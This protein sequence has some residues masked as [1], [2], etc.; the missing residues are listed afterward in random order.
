MYKIYIEIT[1]KDEQDGTLFLFFY[2]SRKVFYRYTIA[3]YRKKKSAN[4][5]K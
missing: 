1:E 2:V 4:K 5:R 3:F